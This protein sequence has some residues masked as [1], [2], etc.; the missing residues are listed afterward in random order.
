LR[1]T[2]HAFLSLAASA[3]FIPARSSVAGADSYP[4]RPIHLIVGFPP[5]GGVDIVARLV[6]QWLS[7]HLGQQVIVDNKPGAGGNIATAIVARSA[8]DGYTLT[9]VGTVAAINPAFYKNPGFDF[10]RDIAPVAGLMRVPMVLEVTPAL[11]VTTVPALIAYA[12]ANPGKLNMASSG[13]GT[14]GHVAGELFQ[15]M[16]GVK[17]LHVPYRGETPALNDLIAGRVQVTFNPLPASIGFLKAGKLRA[18]AMT[19]TTR[20]QI[21]P[22]VPCVDDFVPGYEAS[23]WYGIGAPKQTPAAIVERLNKQINGALAD[24]TIHSRLAALGGMEL[25]GSPSAFGELIAKETAKWAKVVKF[26]GIQPQ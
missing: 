11:P 26:A 4:S 18:L 20:S 6:A 7:Q 25:P 5:G 22:D 12:K 14:A 15:M 9:Y 13:I 23:V 17:L 24:P 10:I 19:T 8:P 16:T 3:V 1:L 21:F 2:R